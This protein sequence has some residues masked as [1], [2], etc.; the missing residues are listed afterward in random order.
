[1]EAMSEGYESL[2]KVARPTEHGDPAVHLQRCA[3]C[4][5]DTLEFDWVN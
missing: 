4:L 1:M 5:E 2:T 3:A